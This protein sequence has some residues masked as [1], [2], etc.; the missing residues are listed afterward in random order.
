MKKSFILIL[1]IIYHL[2]QKIII[3]FIVFFPSLI[4]YFQDINHYDI[5]YFMKFFLIF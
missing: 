2:E 1:E 4:N 5:L 3:F